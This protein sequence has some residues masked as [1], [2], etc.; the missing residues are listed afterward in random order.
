[1]FNI[2]K[3]EMEL[4]WDDKMISIAAKLS[5]KWNSYKR[6]RA[7]SE[8]LNCKKGHPDFLTMKQREDILDKLFNLIFDSE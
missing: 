7:S 8:G 5:N 1:M 3:V 4:I 6:L 2:K